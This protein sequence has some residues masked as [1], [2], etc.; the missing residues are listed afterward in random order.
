VI[1]ACLKRLMGIRNLPL[2]LALSLL[3]ASALNLPFSQKQAVYTFQVTFDIT[4]S[5]N[6]EDVA[7]GGGAV[8]RLDLAK[9]AAK[10]LL[11]SLPCGSRIGWSV[12]TGHRVTLLVTPLEVCGHHDGLLSSL[13]NIDGRMRW[14]EASNI[15]KGLF[16][17]MR[18][19][20]Q[21]GDDIDIVFISD[22][23]E[24]P[25]I[26]EGLTGMPATAGL[27]VGGLVIG[28]GGDKPSPI[29]KIDAEGK[30]LGYWGQREVVQRES[31]SLEERQE[32]LSRL[33]EDHLIRLAQQAGLFYARLDSA[34]RLP[35]A[36]AR[37][38]LAKSASVEADFH[39]VPALL[40]LLALCVRFFPFSY[41]TA[42]PRF[43]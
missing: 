27:E 10:S 31:L 18:T 43:R 22:G 29:P 34:G 1:A 41:A 2:V 30:L 39:W 24:A 13:D 25:P 6:V 3:A 12:F 21:I 4:Q 26:N 40:A 16:Q 5:M 36:V 14:I 23:H 19:A 38:G 28:V 37:S 32:H 42:L 8:S 17:S 15:G 35:E 33:F 9:A 20:R 7:H 11:L